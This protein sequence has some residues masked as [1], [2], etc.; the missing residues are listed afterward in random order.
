MCSSQRG[1]LFGSSDNLGDDDDNDDDLFSVMSKSS[2]V[3]K[4]VSTL[5]LHL[6]LSGFLEWLQA[7]LIVFSIWLNKIDLIFR[8][9]I[10]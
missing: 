1:G 3:A 6:T 2:K 10:M 5:L 9:D 8:Y 7:A 4:S